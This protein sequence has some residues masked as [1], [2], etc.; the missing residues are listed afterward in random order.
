MSIRGFEKIHQG[1]PFG[2][3]VMSRFV[4]Y[5][6]FANLAASRRSHHVGAKKLTPAAE[7][8]RA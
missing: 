1:R 2:N 6:P 5:R 3:T 7:K 4:R 8:L